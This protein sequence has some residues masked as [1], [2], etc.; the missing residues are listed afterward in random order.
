VFFSR[1]QRQ[2]SYCFFFSLKLYLIN[3][4]KI[5]S[6]WKK[7]VYVFDATLFFSQ[8]VDLFFNPVKGQKNQVQTQ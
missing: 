5:D 3:A 8:G 1:Y 4:L 2:A 6:T 7:T